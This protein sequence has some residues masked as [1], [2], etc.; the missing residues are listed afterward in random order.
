[1]FGNTKKKTVTDAFLTTR[2][3]TPRPFEAPLCLGS[4]LALLAEAN[5]PP[6][7]PV[8]RM[9]RSYRSALGGETGSECRG[10]GFFKLGSLILCG[11]SNGFKWVFKWFPNGC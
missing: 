5:V 10:R 4:S 2:Q 7:F 8:Q 1:M 6:G 11:F 9:L 3:R